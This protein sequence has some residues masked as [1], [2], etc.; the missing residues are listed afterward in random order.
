ML[1]DAPAVGK[2][3]PTL[4]R[5][6]GL[7]AGTVKCRRAVPTPVPYQKTPVADVDSELPDDADAELYFMKDALDTDEVAFSVYRM[8]PGARGLEHDHADSG[9]EEVYYVVNGGVD[10]Q[11]DAETVSLEADEALRVDPE[12]DRQIVNRDH[13]S[14]LVLVGAPR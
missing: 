7:A 9:Q 11:F 2:T 10:V 3:V 5:R 4:T 1:G 14:E 13:Y 8:E 6:P 12:E